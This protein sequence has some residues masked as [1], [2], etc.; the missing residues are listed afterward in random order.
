VQNLACAALLLPPQERAF[1]LGERLDVLSQV[2]QP[3]IIPH[4]AEFEGKR[5]PYEV[6][7]AAHLPVRR[8]AQDGRFCCVHVCPQVCRQYAA[9]ACMC[10]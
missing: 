10:G 8:V 2:S 5:F 9:E 6:R 4:M 7:H 1:E 3:A